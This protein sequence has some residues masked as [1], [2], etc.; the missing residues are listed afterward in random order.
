MKHRVQPFCRSSHL[1]CAPQLK[2][3]KKY[4]TPNFVGARSFKV[5]DVD[6][7]KSSSSVSYDR[8]K[9]HVC[10]YLQRFSHQTSQYR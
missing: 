2:F 5:I 8:L 10:A 6:S 1:K 9:Q 3:A 4:Q 7:N